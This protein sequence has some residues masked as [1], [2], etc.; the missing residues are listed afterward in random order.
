[1]RSIRLFLAVVAMGV[2]LPGVTACDG[3][4][5]QKIEQPIVRE[6]D[7]TVKSHIERMRNPQDNTGIAALLASG[8]SPIAEIGYPGEQRYII[9]GV[10]VEGPKDCRRKPSDERPH[11][12]VAYEKVDDGF[13]ATTGVRFHV[14]QVCIIFKNLGKKGHPREVRLASPNFDWPVNSATLDA[15]KL[16][17]DTWTEYVNQHPAEV[18]DVHVTMTIANTPEAPLNGQGNTSERWDYWYTNFG[19]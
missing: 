4:V 11:V 7:S 17:V 14:D 2:L 19:W 13:G 3:P 5:E 15:L 1:M 9:F 6:V 10:C 18:P 12:A 8:R 16:L